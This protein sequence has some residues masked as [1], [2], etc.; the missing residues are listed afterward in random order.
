MLRI[1]LLLLAFIVS[2]ITAQDF[3][4]QAVEESL[5]PIRP[6]VPGKT[7]FWNSQAK[8]FI[9]A[10]AFDF[11]TVENATSYRFIGTSE[12]GSTHTFDAPEP[13]APLTPVWKDLP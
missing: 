2:P 12:D 13:W 7:P 3:H 4:Q 6:G 8:Q 5:A 9:W 11:K 1:S 10:P